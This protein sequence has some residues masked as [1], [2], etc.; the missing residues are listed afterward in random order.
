MPTLRKR[1]VLA[2]LMSCLLVAT[3]HADDAS[4]RKNL[5][6]RFPG[7]QISSITKTPY[8]GLY[9]VVVDGQIAYTDENADYLFLGNVIDTKTRKNLTQERLAK[10]NAINPANLPLDHALKFVKGDGSRK[11]YVFSDPECPFCKRLE[12]ELTKVTNITVYVFPY[13]LETLHPGTTGVAKAIWCSK[14]RNKAWQNALLKNSVPKNDGKCDNPIDDDLNLGQKLHITGT[15]TLIFSNGDIIP[16]AM[17]ASELEDKLLTIA[18]Q[19]KRK[20]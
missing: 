15:P 14:D 7:T 16:G 9:E 18:K 5:S 11:L 3:A 6:A 8:A 17:P 10:L 20:K 19:D 13:P 4:I 1:A 2:S 12:Q